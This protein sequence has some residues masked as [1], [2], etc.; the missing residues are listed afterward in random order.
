MGN[1]MNMSHYEIQ[2]DFM[3]AEYGDE[4][5]YAGW[6]PAIA[7]MCLLPP[8]VAT[9]KLASIPSGRAIL[10][11]DAFMRKMYACQR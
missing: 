4:V 2:R 10:N 7:L 6:N 11:A 5:M 8:I 3:E 9:Y 1:A